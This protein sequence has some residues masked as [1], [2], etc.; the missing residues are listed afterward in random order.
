[1]P[2]QYLRVILQAAVGVIALVAVYL[3]AKGREERGL[4]WGLVAVV[5]SV[6]A[7]QLL[8][9]YLDQ[10]TAV[11][12]TLFQFGFMLLILQH[13]HWYLSPDRHRRVGVG[14]SAVAATK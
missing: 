12:P 4:Q 14:A 5:L 1:V 8:T 7:L 11:I 13:R 2:V 6:T 3:I 10:F 9:F